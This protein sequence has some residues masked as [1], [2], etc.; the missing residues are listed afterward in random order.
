[1]S[2]KRKNRPDRS[3]ISKQPSSP[4]EPPSPPEEETVAAGAESTPLP[5]PPSPSP[6]MLPEPVTP[7]ET[8][9]PRSDQKEIKDP[10]A[11]Y[12]APAYEQDGLMLFAGGLEFVG[13]VEKGDLDEAM[14]EIVASNPI[15]KRLTLLAVDILQVRRVETIQQPTR[16]TMG[17]LE[18]TK[19]F[20]R[21]EP[22]P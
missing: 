9:S 4:S 13:V 8:M 6:E 5:P 1:M 19:L 11:L 22:K 21:A 12:R 20:G 2:K 17:P 16:A 7:A 14:D 10:V 3:W 15:Y 18:A